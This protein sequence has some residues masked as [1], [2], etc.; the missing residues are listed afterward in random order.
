MEDGDRSTTKCSTV[1]LH[2]WCAKLYSLVMKSRTPFSEFVRCANH[3]QRSNLVSHSP[4]FPIPLPCLV[5]ME[6]MPSR[7]SSRKRSQLYFR[8]ALNLV[9]LALN[10]WWSDGKFIDMNLIGEETFKAATANHFPP[11]WSLAGGRPQ[12]PFQSGVGGPED[13]EFD[14]TFG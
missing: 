9:V 8:R 10:F 14:C 3:L 2:V 11:C 13:A 12:A 7:L 6:S 4:A 5:D 1:S